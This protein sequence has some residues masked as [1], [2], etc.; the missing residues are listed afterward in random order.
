MDNVTPEPLSNK[1]AGMASKNMIANYWSEVLIEMG[2]EYEWVDKNSCFVCGATGRL[3]RAHIHPVCKGGSNDVE[4]LH[5]LC[6]TCHN[7]SEMLTGDV[8]WRWYKH[9]RSTDF[10]SPMMRYFNKIEYL[11]PDLKVL[12]EEYEK[13]PT[14]EE[15]DKFVKELVSNRF[16]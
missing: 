12:N 14:F 16:I 1:R 15:R 9:K 8:Y 2:I 4:N 5:I 10:K 7:E 6:P 3:E 13:L 11:F